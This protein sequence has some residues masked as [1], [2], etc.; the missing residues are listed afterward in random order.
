M[1]WLGIKHHLFIGAEAVIRSS[2][3]MSSLWYWR[4]VLA[5][6]TLVTPRISGPDGSF[7][8]DKSSIGETARARL[9]R[10]PPNIENTVGNINARYEIPQ[11]I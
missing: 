6:L 10:L 2:N 8:A 9:C 4:H 7:A 3:G 5:N 11:K 1:N